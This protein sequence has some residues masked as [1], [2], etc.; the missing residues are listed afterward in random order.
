M[1]CCL[2]RE[3][4]ISTPKWYRYRGIRDS[5]DDRYFAGSYYGES[6]NTGYPK[7]FPYVRVTEYTVSHRM[8]IPSPLAFIISS[9]DNIW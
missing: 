2:N 3:V 4:Q 7:Y 8:I 9:R 1:K 6:G 5:F